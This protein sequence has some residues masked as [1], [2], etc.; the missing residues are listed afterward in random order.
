MR[1][2]LKG[3]N[4]E[5]RCHS[6][7]E[8]FFVGRKKFQLSPSLLRSLFLICH[9][10]SSSSSLSGVA[11]RLSCHLWCQRI[12]S[13]DTRTCYYPDIVCLNFIRITSM[14]GI[15]ILFG[16]RVKNISNRI[17][18]ILCIQMCSGLTSLDAWNWPVVSDFFFFRKCLFLFHRKE[19]Q[20]AAKW[21]RFEGGKIS[22]S[23]RLKMEANRIWVWVWRN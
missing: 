7:G 19:A 8:K 20:P 3:K 2:I 15:W 9:L 12:W 18:R 4:K 17:I 6:M 13:R 21:A 16:F 23:L 14:Y 1:R 11:L 22:S 5:L 10:S